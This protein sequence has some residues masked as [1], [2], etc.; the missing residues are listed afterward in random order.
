M[1]QFISTYEVPKPA[2]LLPGDGGL[3]H[4]LKEFGV[5]YPLATPIENTQL[6]RHHPDLR[7][8]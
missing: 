1:A 5:L 4:Y 6:D 8:R 2:K 3:L 7:L